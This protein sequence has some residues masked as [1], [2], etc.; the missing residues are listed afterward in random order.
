MKVKVVVGGNTESYIRE[1]SDNP[2]QAMSDLH[3]LGSIG[4]IDVTD[5]GGYNLVIDGVEIF[6]RYIILGIDV[7]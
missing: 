5:P 6:F 1:I 4:A 3:Y 7:V 2:R